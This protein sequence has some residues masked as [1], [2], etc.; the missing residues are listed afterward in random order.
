MKEIAEINGEIV[1]GLGLGKKLGFP[2]I[3]LGY[4]G[5]LSGVFWGEVLLN[6]E[7]I[8]AAVHVGKKPTVDADL[9]TLE[10]Y[11]LDWKDEYQNIGRLNVR[12]LKKIRDTEKF[13][14]LQELK[15][16]IKQDVDFVKSCYNQKN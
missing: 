13:A 10:A 14:N 16:Q 7:W 4:T 2:T 15:A 11:L 3:N 12:L 8:P 5:E 9:R 1:S 6:E